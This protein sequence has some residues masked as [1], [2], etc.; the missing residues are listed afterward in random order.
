M[1][2]S[3]AEFLAGIFFMLIAVIFFSFATK[4]PPAMNKA[5]LGPA[6]F[7]IMI[8]VIIAILAAALIY[9]GLKGK[10]NPD[11]PIIKIMR[12]NSVFVVMLLLMAY[13]IIMPIIG[14]YITTALFFPALLWFAGEKS[15][16]NIILISIGFVVFAKTVF[17]ML[18]GVPLP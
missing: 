5:D 15:P 2:M 18:L 7:P 11:Q 17:N 3:V 10:N 6:T 14:Y 8:T 4:F 13:V 12:K 1:K 9:R 16:K